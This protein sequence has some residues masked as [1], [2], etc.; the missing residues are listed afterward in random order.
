MNIHT[1]SA[2][3]YEDREEHMQ[4]EMWVHV[5]YGGVTTDRRFCLG[6]EA[7][8]ESA[9]DQHDGV[10]DGETLEEEPDHGSCHDG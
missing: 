5:R 10:G 9:D 4:E 2:L 1:E 7:N 6:R 8:R 3:E